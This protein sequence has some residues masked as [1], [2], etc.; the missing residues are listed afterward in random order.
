[1]T[2]NHCIFSA[3]VLVLLNVPYSSLLVPQSLCRVVSAKFFDEFLGPARDIAGKVNGVNALEDDVV[4]FHGIG[5]SEGWCSGQELEHE[6]S[7]RP[8]VCA[9]VVSL[10]EDDLWS[11]VLGSAAKRPRLSAHHQLLGEAKVHQL[12]V[13]S[14]IQ[15]Q[16]LRLQVS[17]DN[18]SRVEVVKGFNNTSGVKP[19]CTIV[20]VPSIPEKTDIFNDFLNDA[21]TYVVVQSPNKTRMKTKRE[22]KR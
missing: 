19:R 17:V 6:N 1:M 5:A 11:H 3:F 18:P 13:S 7:Q 8:I 4:G 14:P 12:D 21:R 10:V 15:Q 9:D 2:I 22:D 16:V 20:K